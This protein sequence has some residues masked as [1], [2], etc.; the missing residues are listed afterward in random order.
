MLNDRGINS[1][2]TNDGKNVPVPRDKRL[3]L[4]LTELPVQWLLGLCP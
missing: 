3:A 4:G 2:I 1:L